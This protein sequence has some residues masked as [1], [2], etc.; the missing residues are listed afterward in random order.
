MRESAKISVSRG[1]F[2]LMRSLLRLERSP[3]TI[4]PGSYP[5]QA[6]TATGFLSGFWVIA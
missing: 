5:F 2:Y 6:M 4:C 3:W 1:L